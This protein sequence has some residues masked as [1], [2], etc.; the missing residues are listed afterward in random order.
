MSGNSRNCIA[1]RNVSRGDLETSH[2]H[3]QSWFAIVIK[4]KTRLPQ[5][6]CLGYRVPAVKGKLWPIFG[7][8]CWCPCWCRRRRNFNLDLWTESLI[9]SRGDVRGNGWRDVRLIFYGYAL[10]RNGL[11]L[12]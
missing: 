4:T 9:K 7:Q 2:L 1:A 6:K 12:S 5:I 8:C 3:V 11:T 10:R